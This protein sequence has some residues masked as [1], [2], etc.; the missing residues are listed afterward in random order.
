MTVSKGETRNLN[1]MIKANLRRILNQIPA[2]FELYRNVRDHLDR[3]LPSIETRW[4]F[5]LA[6]N[7]EMGQGNF[8]PKETEVVRNLIS[9]V[10]VV[11]NIGANIGYYCCHALSLGKQVIAVEPV[12]RNMHYLLRN[13]RENGWESKAEIFPLALGSDTNILNIWGGGTGASLVKGWAS[14][15]ESYV[16]QVPVMTLD[17]ILGTELDKKRSLIIVDVEGAEYMLLQGATKTLKNKL[18]PIWLVEIASTEHQPIKGQ[19]NPDYEKTFS[20]FFENLYRAFPINNLCNEIS[21]I[22]VTNV[23]QG[24]LLPATHNYLFRR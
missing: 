8:E 21:E 2:V 9:E 7:Y 6:G 5:T 11:V 4:G 10:D 3:N 15:P 13:I 18:D 22:D 12:A 19:M 1:F 14:A 23:A 16:T 17:R 24:Q 20:I